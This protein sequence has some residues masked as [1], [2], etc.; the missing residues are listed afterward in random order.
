M[1]AA[2]TA[3]AL[4]QGLSLPA[5]PE[6][7]RAP[8]MVYVDRVGMVIGVRGGRDAPPVNLAGLPAYV[9]KAFVSVEDRRFYEHQ[10]F[11]ALGIA[12]AVMTDLAK[13]RTAQGAS[14][15]TQ[16][17]ARNLFL[18]NDQTMERKAQELLYAVQL[19]QKFSKDQILSLYLS[20]VYF[21]SGAYGIEAA[22]RRFFAKP[23]SKLTIREAAT[24]AGIL[25]NPAGYS[26]V[27]E[28]ERSAERTAIVLQ[29]MVETGAITEAQRKYALAHPPKVQQADPLGPAQY[30]VDWADI[31]ARRLMGRQSFNQDVTIETTLDGAMETQA[32]AATD[33]VLARFKKAGVEQ[34]AL[35][36]MDGQ[37]RVRAMIGGSD[38]A[39]TQYNR[40][41]QAHRQ[42]GSSWKPMVYLTALDAGRTPDMVVV[43]EPITIDG[44]SPR[45]H[46]NAFMGPITLETALG[47]S[48]N[49][50]AARLADEVGRPNVAN[51]AKRL[52]VTS[53]LNLDPA[54]A[55]GTSLVTPLEMATAYTAFSN[56]GQR[57]TPYAIER[58]RIG[59]RVVYQRRDEGRAQ[60]IG[61]PS[62]QNMDRML[63]QV[64]A[65]GTG[66]AAAIPGYDIAGKTG[67]TT[68][69]KDA[70][71]DGFTGGLTTVVWVGRD[72]NT[73]MGPG[74]AGGGPPAELWRRFMAAAL[75][76]AGATPIPAGPAPSAQALSPTPVAGP[77]QPQATMAPIPDRDP[78][79]NLLS[80]TTEETPPTSSSPR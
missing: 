8:S 38:Y 17:L 20:R 13:G 26:P 70:W 63:R 49:T 73:A 50:V 45:N 31:E 56:G 72:D 79:T 53:N 5:L 75:P 61:N 80:N 15:I 37:G 6:I 27:N 7:K 1:F 55:L 10:G 60:V 36:A 43:D 14:T 48:V 66:H 41:W 18:S 4:I 74:A 54:M 19:E 57:V 22:S 32:D 3:A 28:P 67:T 34:A 76:R 71:F 24:L 2:V 35:V 16:Q 12:R 21:G 25:K 46:T 29:T 11:D 47:Q 52:G 30:F 69:N 78:V 65:T 62:L 33:T 51:T 39:T 9:P 44:W 64:V 42:A 77:M 59:G 23:A 40:A 68:D 58:I